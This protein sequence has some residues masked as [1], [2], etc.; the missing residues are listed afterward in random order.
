MRRA[1]TQHPASERTAR[2]GERQPVHP[3]NS[4]RVQAPRHHHR[5]ATTE[6]PHSR[7]DVEL[8][9]EHQSWPTLRQADARD[10]KQDEKPTLE[11]LSQAAQGARATCNHQRP[12][13]RIALEAGLPASLPSSPLLSRSIRVELDSALP[14]KA[15]AQ[16]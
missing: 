5:S 1:P 15:A 7:P 11:N 2:A 8:R 3:S 14:A 10:E 12:L 9:L 4:S 6:T 16:R 13:R